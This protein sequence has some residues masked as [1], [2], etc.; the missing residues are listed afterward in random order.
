MHRQEK[1]GDIKHSCLSHSKA[2]DLLN[3]KPQYDLYRGLK[4]TYEYDMT[5]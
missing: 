5:S 2:Y 3:W 4:E 1:S